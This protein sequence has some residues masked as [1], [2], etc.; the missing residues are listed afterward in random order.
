MLPIALQS[1]KVLRQLDTRGKYGVSRLCLS[2]DNA[3]LLTV[4]YVQ[5]LGAVEG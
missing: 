3:Q 4:S 5:T 1:G 2:P